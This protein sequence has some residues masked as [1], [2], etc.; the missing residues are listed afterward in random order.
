MNQDRLKLFIILAQGLG[1]LVT[2][3]CSFLGGI[4]IFN[5]QWLFA[6]PVSLLFV[7]AVYYLVIYF[8]KEKENR[9]KRGYPPA[10]YYLFGVYGIISLVLSVFVLHFYNV[11]VNEKA[12]VQEIGLKKVAGLKLLYTEYDK[13]YDNFLTTAEIQIVSLVNQYEDN[14]ADRTNI[15]ASLAARPLNIDHD[16][17]ASIIANTNRALAIKNQLAQRK[18]GFQQFKNQILGSNTETFIENQSSIITNWDR[19]KLVKSMVDLNERLSEDY[20]K[21][22]G[23]LVDKINNTYAI[24]GFNPAVYKDESLINEPLA[25][26]AKHLGP[27]SLVVL[28]FFQFLI[29]LPYFLTKG[30]IY[31]R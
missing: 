10:F 8:C 23:N 3:I 21:L 5:G 25:L 31:G 9:K 4:Y 6:F 14:V 13:N 18:L 11:E 17:L 24:T 16:N 1:L 12:N 15:E 22:N 30:R 28:L 26:A 2:L 20:E 19:F 27:M 7:V 29:L